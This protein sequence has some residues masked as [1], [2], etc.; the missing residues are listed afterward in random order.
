M[1]GP[2][3]PDCRLALLG[4]V[5]R[6][7]AGAPRLVPADGGPALAVWSSAWYQGEV[8][9]AIVAWKRQGR[10]ELRLEM[11]R[12]VAR[13]AEAAGRVLAAVSQSIAVVPV[14]SRL[15]R[16]LN[17]RGGTTTAL[18][19]AAAEALAGAGLAA[20]VADVL[21]R[22]ASASEQAGKSLRERVAGREGTTGLRRVPRAPCLLVDDV[23]TTGATLLDAERTLAGAGA[24]V[25]GAVVL[26]VSPARSR[27]VRPAPN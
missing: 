3:C 20:S 23:L 14:P 12:A 22:S 27:D 9:Q 25:L 18:A 15:I 26:A 7:E 17:R 16:R 24:A 5:A 1:A 11:C 6:R 4:P 10:A 2:L 13:S 8:R 21:T 19:L